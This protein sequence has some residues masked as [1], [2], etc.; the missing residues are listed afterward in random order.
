[1]Q[2]HSLLATKLYIPPIRPELVS[3]PRLIE[4]L[5]AGLPTRIGL[6]RTPDPFSRALTLVSAPAGF[7]KT[8]LVS[9]WVQAISGATPPIAIA[10]LSLDE[11][12]NDPA[13]FL[14]YLI[15]ALRTIEP[16]IEK[17]VLSALQAP[18]PPPAEAVLISLINEIAAIPSNI[19]L[20]LDDHHTI[21][22]SPVDNALAFLLERL[23]VNMHLVIATREDPHLPLA[24]LRAGGQLTEVRAS[25]LRFTSSE[26]AEF[27][28]QAMGLDLSAE[29]IAALERRTEGWIAGLQLAG[30]SMQ[31]QEDA[32]S[33]IQSFTGSH[34]YVLDYLVE[35][36][37]EQQSESVQT[38]LLQT[39]ILDR[40]TGS[41]CDALLAEGSGSEAPGRSQEILEYLEQS[42]LFLVPLDSRRQWYRYHHL[43]GELLR[44][45]LLRTLPGRIPE[46]HR[47][48]SAWY[49]AKG[50]IREAV[51][52][53][54]ADA[55]AAPGA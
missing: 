7:G 13:R 27:L 30:L 1:M 50:H 42:N 10:W 14:A 28:N 19:I 16:S 5:N 33:L 55:D 48:A 41:L 6:S 24:R 52:H 22:S 35:E 34:R 8:T 12:D 4:R 17:G 51:Q 29:D 9:E 38:F 32:T 2:Q 23:P 39:A 31:G 53:A 11:G 15:A 20:V 26:A 40:L 37:L 3:R 25:D 18:Q 36:V 44:Q 46:L 47:R 45:R 21:E 54:L 43:F 49:E